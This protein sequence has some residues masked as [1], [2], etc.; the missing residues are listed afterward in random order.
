MKLIKGRCMTGD[1][2]AFREG[3]T[4][5][6]NG[7]DL[8]EEWR[9]DFLKEANERSRGRGQGNDA[10]SPIAEFFNRDNTFASG[11][12]ELLESETSEDEW[13]DIKK[14]A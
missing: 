8:A 7:R 9:N 2:E 4:W 13:Y 5:F 1:V 3:T 10:R 11:P 6:R 12:A 14:M